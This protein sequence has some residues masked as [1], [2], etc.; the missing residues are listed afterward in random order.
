MFTR[1][2]SME[3]QQLVDELMAKMEQQRLQISALE[4]SRNQSSSPSQQATVAVEKR[5][6]GFSIPDPIKLIP[7][8]SGE[9][10]MLSSWIDSVDQKIAYCQATINDQTTVDR[11]MPLW[12]GLIRD[13]IVKDANDVLVRNQVKNDWNEIKQALKDELGDKRDLATLSTKIAQLKQG[14]QDLTSY[15]QSCKKLKADINANLLAND[16]TRPCVKILMVNYEAMI[17]N[18]FIDGLPDH[19]SSLTRI[20]RPKNLQE[21]YEGALEQH[22]ANQRRREKLSKFQD[23]NTSRNLNS[24]S[25]GYPFGQTGRGYNAPQPQNRPQNSNPHNSNS[26]QNNRFIPQQKHASNFIPQHNNRFSPQP[27]RLQIKPEI[28]SQQTRQYH[29]NLNHHESVQPQC[30]QPDVTGYDT[31]CCNCEPS[32]GQMTND[33]HQANIPVEENLNSDSPVNGE[34]LNFHLGLDIPQEE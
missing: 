2:M 22:L 14:N 21:A 32:Y 34:N 6:D 26:S 15:Y 9:P 27:G 24:N 23:S 10:A 1:T 25:K 31:Q 16:D 33:E 12:T 19:L 3:L 20:Y 28:M 30:E 18:A 13:K 5:F 17:T 29:S 7:T 11:V 8:F 4:A